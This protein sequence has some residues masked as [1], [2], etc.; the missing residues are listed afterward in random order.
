M[1]H[2]LLLDQRL[3][4]SERGAGGQQRSNEKSRHFDLLSTSSPSFMGENI[5]Q[6]ALVVPSSEQLMY[7]SGSPT[8]QVL[9]R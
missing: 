7:V 6:D 2:K 4:V 8:Q 1:L 5:K 9:S 3:R